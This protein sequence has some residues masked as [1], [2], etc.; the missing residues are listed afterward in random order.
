MNLIIISASHRQNA[1]SAKVGNYI[2][3]HAKQFTH[4][5]H[6]QLQDF[7]LPFWDGSNNKGAQWQSLK[8]KVVAADALILITPEWN[9]MASPLLKNF[10]MMCDSEMTA[11]KPVI[12]TSVSSGIG[13]TYPIA[14]LKMDGAKN[15]HLIPLSE[16]LIIRSVGQMLNSEVSSEHDEQIRQ[17]IDFSLEMLYRYAQSLATIRSSLAT[18]PVP[19]SKQFSF[20]M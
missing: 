2:E 13:G 9:G 7:D 10:L 16:H 6:I 17:R 19:N 3:E 15:N 4:V 1:Q 20:G 18:H 11:H 8:Q 12:Y 5:K 14:E